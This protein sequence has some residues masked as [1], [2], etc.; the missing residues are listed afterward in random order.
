MYTLQEAEYL[1][2]YYAEKILDRKI[3]SNDKFIRIEIVCV[4]DKFQVRC[5]RASSGYVQLE[6]ATNKLELIS[7]TE[8]LLQNKNHE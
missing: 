7:P 5:S 6:D 2:D 3:G 1:R 4:D 8:V